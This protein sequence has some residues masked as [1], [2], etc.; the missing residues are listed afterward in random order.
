ML[1]DLNECSQPRVKMPVFNRWD[2]IHEGWYMAMPSRDLPVGG[3]A[4][5]RVYGQRLVFFRGEDGEVRA[6]D[7]F[8]PHM[9][10]DLGIG[11]VVGEHLRCFFHHW[12]FDGGGRCVH[13]PVRD[14]P[15]EAARLEGYAVEERYGY[16]WVYPG[17]DPPPGGVPCPKGLEG[18]EIVYYSG[19]SFTRRCHSHV[20][21]IN[22]IDPQHLRTVHGVAM[23]L[24]VEIEE[25]DE[26]QLIDFEL[27]GELPAGT[28]RERL[29]RAL[30]GSRYGYAIRFSGGTFGFLTGL[31]YTSLF[32]GRLP[33]PEI[34]MMYGY[35][36]ERVGEVRMQPIFLT[37]RR[38]GPLGA[39]VSAACL[40]VMHAVHLVLK[41]ED[42]LIYNN[43]RFRPAALLPIDA[44]VTR[45]MQWIN[46]RRPSK[47]VRGE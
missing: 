39:L 23:R 25:D 46:R 13:V 6:L 5:R 8:C 11:K 37:K 32:G 10:A 18:E 24:D 4:S 36:S 41:T 27:S 29:I 19:R 21:M 38:P 1:T 3:V 40:L 17:R 31:K 35:T 14:E 47:W 22:G 26:R 42:G 34:H 15:P 45:L 30:V 2:V 43:I 44:P 28:G 16:V 9:G 33:L 20:T 7:A 12:T